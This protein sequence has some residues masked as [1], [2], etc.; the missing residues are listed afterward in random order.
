L[1]TIPQ[2][3]RFGLVRQ[4]LEEAAQGDD[5]SETIPHLPKASETLARI[6]KVLK[7]N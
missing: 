6:Q 1:K 3:L 4:T 7:K 2:F 5:Q